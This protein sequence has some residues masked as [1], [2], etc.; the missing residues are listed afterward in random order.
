MKK[1]TITYCFLL[2]LLVSCSKD[3][4]LKSEGIITGIDYSLCACCGGWFIEIESNTYRFFNLPEDS[5]FDLSNESFPLA[6]KLSWSKDTL[7]CLGDEILITAIIK[8]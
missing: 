2:L 7:A 3:R 8:K 4:Q 6:V 5:K 1:L